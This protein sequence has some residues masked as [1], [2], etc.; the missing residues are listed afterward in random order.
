MFEGIWAWYRQRAL[1]KLLDKGSRAYS[2]ILFRYDGEKTETL[3]AGADTD[4]NWGLLDVFIDQMLNQGHNE[5]LISVIHTIPEGGVIMGM[6]WRNRV[7]KRWFMAGIHEME[8]A[9]KEVKSWCQKEQRLG[10]D[11]G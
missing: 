8:V 7:I 11:K 2:L 10:Q 3:L 5:I 6:S 4:A 9:M 1:S